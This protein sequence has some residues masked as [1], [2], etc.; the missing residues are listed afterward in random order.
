MG[1]NRKFIY[2]TAHGAS[3][4][5]GLVDLDAAASARVVSG[6]GPFQLTADGENLGQ[7]KKRKDALP[8]LHRRLL[9]GDVGPAYRIRSMHTDEV[10]F[11]CREVKLA[12]DVIDTSGDD[13]AD[14]YWTALKAEFPNAT[15][16][17]ALVCKP[18][19]QHRFGNA[20]DAGFPSREMGD[21][22]ARWA[23]SHS[24]E[25]D[26]RN[27]IYQTTIWHE[28]TKS[29]YTGVPHVSHTHADFNPTFDTNLPC[30]LRP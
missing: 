16:L 25:F 24:G 3:K 14:R 29:P 1:D 20:V 6:N 10:V 28:G 27:L 5:L 12:A 30:G 18:D 19:S 17:G 22:M 9:V 7:P 11:T 8:A 26:I 23:I 2:V 4:P 21:A 15:F 13:K